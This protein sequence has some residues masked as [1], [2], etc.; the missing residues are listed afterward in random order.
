MFRDRVD[1]GRQL[2]KRL[3]HYRDRE[4]TVVLGIPRGGVPVAFEVA[5]ALRVPLDILIVRKLGAPGQPELAMGAIASGGVRILNDEVV[6]ALGVSEQELESISA[7]KGA[8][9]QRREQVYRGARPRF[10]LEGKT[11]ILV[12]DGIAT[13]ASMLAAIAA[14]RQAKP[15]RIVVATAVA[16]ASAQDQVRPAVDEFVT[17]LSPDWFFGIGEF[18]RDFGQT[19][20]SEVRELLDRASARLKASP[21]TSALP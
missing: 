9:L 14:V 12:D 17:V 2:S 5:N 8:E 15:A 3:L 13:G 19:Q 20:D 6:Q 1:A 18:Y 21:E 11:V 7:L 16:P 4:D 10:P